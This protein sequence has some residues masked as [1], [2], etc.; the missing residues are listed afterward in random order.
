[1]IDKPVL[2]RARRIIADSL[3]MDAATGTG[4]A[5]LAVIGEGR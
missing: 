1:M 3:R 5:G 4:G 2:D